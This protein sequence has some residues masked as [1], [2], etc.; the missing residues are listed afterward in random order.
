MNSPRNLPRHKHKKL[1]QAFQKTR[2]RDSGNLR[3]QLTNK[4]SRDLNTRDLNTYDPQKHYRGSMTKETSPK[5]RDR[6]SMTEVA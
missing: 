4:L 1:T 3:T 5:K 2:E 6:R